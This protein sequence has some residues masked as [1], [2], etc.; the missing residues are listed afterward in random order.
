MSAWEAAVVLSSGSV[1]SQVH[2]TR[3]GL[4]RPAGPTRRDR[5]AVE[6]LRAPIEVPS[7]CAS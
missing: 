6:T 3:E 1:D 2:V 5:V 4:F 7:A